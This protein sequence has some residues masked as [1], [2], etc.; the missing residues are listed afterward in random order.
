MA[1]ATGT[2]E[3]ADRAAHSIRAGA[4]VR[5]Q[6]AVKL[7]AGRRAGHGA[8]VQ[9]GLTNRSSMA[10]KALLACQKT[11]TTEAGAGVDPACGQA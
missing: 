4:S 5:A 8:G 7:A 1:G 6:A 9:Q 3:Q 2:V 11:S 10:R